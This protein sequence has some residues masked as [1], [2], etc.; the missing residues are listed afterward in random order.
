MILTTCNVLRLSKEQYKVVDTLSFL[1]KNM[2][3][4]GLYMSR[5]HFFRNNTVLK[6]SE[7]WRECKSNENHKILATCAA[8]QTLKIVE[9][10][11]KSFSSLKK[12]KDKGWYQAEVN[13]PHYLPKNG[14][15]ALVFPAREVGC[16]NHEAIIPLSHEFRK[17]HNLKRGEFRIPI[18][19]QINPSQLIELR[20]LPIHGGKF[21]KS[22]WVYEVKEEPS[23]NQDNWLSIDLGVN[24]FATCVDSVTGTAIIYDGKYIKSLNRYYNKEISKYQSIKDKQGI[25]GVTNKI[26]KLWLKRSRQ[27]DDFMNKTVHSIIEHCKSHDIGHLVIGEIKGIKQESNLGRQNNQVI[28][29]TPWGK[30]KSKLE[31]KC[32][33]AGI[34]YHLVDEAYTSQTDAL[35]LDP[36]QKPKSNNRKK[37][38]LFQSKCGKLI[39]ADVNGALNILRKVSSDSVAKQIIGS[40]RVYRPVSCQMAS[41][42]DRNK[43]NCN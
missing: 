42:L 10:S 30:F 29:Q 19:S 9:R 31:A 3:N 24:N 38:G 35:I 28:C 16:H 32:K 13:L 4:Y 25:R 8:D 34:T 5:Q 36:I 33:L 7:L 27:I 11:M 23:L 43:L 21:Y 17:E 12:K 41:Y 22:E 6:F 26:A 40:G 15:F 1:S 2:Y 39:N 14:R 20:I 37:R 18:P